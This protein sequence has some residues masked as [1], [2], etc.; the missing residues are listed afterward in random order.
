MGEITRSV[1]SPVE[2]PV[3]RRVRERLAGMTEEERQRLA[4]VANE[5][6]KRTEAQHQPGM[7]ND[8]AAPDDWA[9]PTNRPPGQPRPGRNP[10]SGLTQ[11]T[12]LPDLDELMAKQWELD[13]QSS[14]PAEPWQ[15]DQLARQQPR[16][17]A[18]G[19]RQRPGRSPRVERRPPPDSWAEEMLEP[20]QKREWPGGWY[21]RSENRS[22]IHREGPAAEDMS[23][24]VAGRRIGERLMGGSI[25]R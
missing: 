19:S 6:P 10:F 5:R 1:A 7:S 21:L 11:A 8:R 13:Q 12:Q 24:R 16:P 25:W 2:L 15:V 3:V 18:T 4:V 23:E 17:G 20:S 14:G 9:Y 22:R